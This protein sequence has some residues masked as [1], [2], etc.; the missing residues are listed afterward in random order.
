MR[1]GQ[2]VNSHLLWTKVTGKQKGLFPSTPT[3]SL[4]G[5]GIGMGKPTHTGSGQVGVRARMWGPSVPLYI[6]RCQR[7]CHQLTMLA[8]ASTRQTHDPLPCGLGG[9]SPSQTHPLRTVHPL[10]PLFFERFIYLKG[11]V[12]QRSIICWFTHQTTSTAR[13]GQAE[14]KSQE[15]HLGFPYEWQDPT[16]LGHHPLLPLYISRKPDWKLE[17]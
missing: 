13:A 17:P 12:R 16:S 14:S 3:Q 8:T 15:P 4:Q 1:A 10:C 7:G 5:G 11:R 9:T 2:L 6:S